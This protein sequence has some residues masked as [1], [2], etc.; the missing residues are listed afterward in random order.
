MEQT[1]I[2]CKSKQK[3]SQICKCKAVAQKILANAQVLEG[4]DK[5]MN[6]L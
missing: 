4:K 6:C 1:N 3:L 5:Q 2:G